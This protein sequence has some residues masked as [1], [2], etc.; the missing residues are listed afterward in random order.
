M[1]VWQASSA[2]A[3][4]DW[5]AAQWISGL[6]SADGKAMQEQMHRHG[7][8]RWYEG[9]GRGDGELQMTGFSVTLFGIGVLEAFFG[10]SVAV[11][12]IGRCAAIACAM[13]AACV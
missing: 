7:A 6:C 4:G 8:S 12:G 9:A 5:G 2:A 10:V 13:Q 3:A 11:R 1:R